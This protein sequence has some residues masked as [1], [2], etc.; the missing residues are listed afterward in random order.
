MYSNMDYSFWASI[1]MVLL[2]FVM[3]CYNIGCQWKINLNSCWALLPMH[4]GGDVE[5][6]IREKDG[7]TTETDSIG[8]PKS[9]WLCLYGM[10]MSTT[11]LAR[12]KTQY[13]TKRVQ[14]VLT[15]KCWSISGQ[16]WTRVPTQQ[17]RW[18]RGI[19]RTL[20]K[21]RLTILTSGKMLAFVSVCL[22]GWSVTDLSP[23]L[24]LQKKYLI[25]TEE[26]ATTAA[27]FKNLNTMVSLELQEEWAQM[28]KNWLID[29]TNPCP[30]RLTVEGECGLSE[31]C[32]LSIVTRGY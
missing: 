14:G 15:V 1:M 25:V 21:T 19:E 18:Q 26:Q 24:S 22:C 30:Y 11:W 4:L 7:A 16:F 28:V 32:L 6:C 20:L 29:K 13:N 5:L 27:Y 17:R 2:P 31:K 3:V 9:P 10:V 12:P 8:K 23:G